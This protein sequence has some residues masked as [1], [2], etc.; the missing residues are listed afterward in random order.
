M[1]TKIETGSLAVFIPAFEGFRVFQDDLLKKL[2]G[3]TLLQ[4]AIDKAV[5]LG[6]RN[7]NIYVLTD[8]EQIQLVSKRSGVQV[9]PMGDGA[10]KITDPY[11]QFFGIA[12]AKYVGTSTLS[13]LL[14]PYS[15]LL[16]TETIT[17]AC[18]ALLEGEEEVLKPVQKERHQFLKGDGD[19]QPLNE[20][21][22]R[23]NNQSHWMES[24]AFTLA[25][26]TAFDGDS[27]KGVSVFPWE[28]GED[29][30]LFKVGDEVW[31][32]GD[33]NRQ[34]SNEVFFHKGEWH[35]TTRWLDRRE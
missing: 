1:G 22:I 14:S 28:V 8:S 30:S 13:L 17:E 9:I 10:Q 26:R 19:I 25:K 15:P 12:I 18:R 11:R 16:K 32:A 4:R 5:A 29:V 23:R 34:G 35:L 21:L 27:N 20:I 6:V 31:Y 3:A 24:N 7:D 33:L 2:G